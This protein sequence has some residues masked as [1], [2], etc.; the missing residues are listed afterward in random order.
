MD[1]IISH[2]NNKVSAEE[3][4]HENIE[5]ELDRTYLY[6]IYNMSLDDKKEK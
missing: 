2:E 6:E 4:A 3:D 1:E 5:S